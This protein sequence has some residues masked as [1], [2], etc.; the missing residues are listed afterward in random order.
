M[1]ISMSTISTDMVKITITE[2]MVYIGFYI[3]FIECYMVTTIIMI[4]MARVIMIRT[5]I[6]AITT[7]VTMNIQQL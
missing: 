1:T 3:L 7:T 2:A 4:M 6:M 5:I